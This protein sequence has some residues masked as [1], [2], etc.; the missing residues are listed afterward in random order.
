MSSQ[1]SGW[2]T[3]TL[4][5]LIASSNVSDKSSLPKYVPL[6][7]KH[8]NKVVLLPSEQNV[9]IKPTNWIKDRQP[10]YSRIR[11]SHPN[12]E[13]RR[14]QERT[15]W[16]KWHYPYTMSSCQ[17]TKEGLL[18]MVTKSIHKSIESNWPKSYWVSNNCNKSKDV[19]LW[20]SSRSQ[21]I[22]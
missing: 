15:T 18:R 21:R 17:S 3:N 2:F 1:E 9:Q 8:S 6:I 13:S 19:K 14:T 12:S 7:D 16:W 4:R 5:E 22:C 10:E 20:T 11:H